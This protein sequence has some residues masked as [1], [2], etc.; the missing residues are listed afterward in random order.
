M[1]SGFRIKKHHLVYVWFFFIVFV[2]CLISFGVVPSVFRYASDLINF[3]IFIISLFYIKK[4]NAAYR[5]ILIGLVVILFYCSLELLMRRSSAVNFVWGI[6]SFFSPIVFLLNILFLLNKLNTKHTIRFLHFAFWLNFI[7]SI[8]EFAMGYINDF[9]GGIFGVASGCNTGQNILLVSVCILDLYLFSKKKAA[10][11]YLICT[12]LCC[13]LIS[14]F[15]ELKIFFFEIGIIIVCYLFG[16]RMTLKKLFLLVCAILSVFVFYRVSVSINAGFAGNWDLDYIISYLTSDRGYTNSGD[17]NRLNGISILSST[18]FANDPHLV[19]FGLGLGTASP[20]SISFVDTSFYVEYSYLHYDWFAYSFVFIETGI[21]GLILY[22]LLLVSIFILLFKKKSNR[23]FALSF[24]AL[25]SMLLMYNDSMIS[26]KN[27]V[28]FYLLFSI[29]LIE[30]FDKGDC[31]D[32]NTE[33][34]ET[35]FEIG[36][37]TLL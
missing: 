33:R 27:L 30:T 15:A 10:F 36:K 35:N 26:F 5:T 25:V 11:P 29:P 12:F 14:I 6:R 37:S 19:M 16:T 8:T 1:I 9:N 20:S 3:G 13:L 22:C 32:K 28:P 24:L 23:Y 7:F 21:I 17:I 31:Y 18:V 2:E 4:T 34:I